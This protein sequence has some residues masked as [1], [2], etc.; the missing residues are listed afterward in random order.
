MHTRSMCVSKTARTLFMLSTL[1]LAASYTSS[2]QAAQ[3][4]G[5]GLHKSVYGGCI[6]NHPGMH[7][8]P[9]PAHPGCWRNGWGQLRCY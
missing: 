2:S 9:A 1:V 5:Y 7:A 6:P 8:T 3:G 4:C